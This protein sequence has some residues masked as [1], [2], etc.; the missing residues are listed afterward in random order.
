MAPEVDLVICFRAARSLLK[1]HVLEE[2]KK[3]EEQYTRLLQ[4]LT[5]A[6]LRAV[7]R[8]GDGLGHLVVFVYCPPSLLKTLVKRERQS[9][10]VSGLAVSDPSPTL[11]PADRLRLVYEFVESSPADGGLG[12][13]PDSPS[14]DRVESILTLHDKDFNQ[15]WIH[16]W[17]HSSI[18]SV[19]QERVREH[20]GDSIA[21]YFFYLHSYTH[22]LIF[23][24]ALGLVFFLFG[25]PYSP[26]YSILLVLWSIIY[27]EW[28]RI[29]ERVLALR[30]GTLG[31]ARV[32]RRRAQ[33][34]DGFPWWK[35]ELRMLVGLPVILFFAAILIS[36]LTG[37]FVFEAFLTQLYT[38]PGHKYIAF[39]P[40]ILFVALVPQ[41]LAIYQAIARRI[42]TWEN[43]PHQSSHAASLALKTFALSAL[44]AYMGL[45]LS[46]FVYVPFGE[47]IM[48]TV[49]VWL[50]E[51]HNSAAALASDHNSTALNATAEKTAN[52]TTSIWN[53]DT[54][55]AGQ[56]LNAG[57]LRDQMFAYTVTNQI[58]NTFVEIGLPFVLRKVNSIKDSLLKK[59][60]KGT[61]INGN[62]TAAAA[63]EPASPTLKKRVVF[64]DEQERGGAAERE[65]LEE[66]RKEVALPVYEEFV[67]YSEMVTQFGYVVL[68][69]TIWPLAPVMALVNNFFELRSDAFKLTVHVRRPLPLRTDS[70]GP[71][72]D[73]LGF[74]TWLGALTNSAL[75]YLFC[76]RNTCNGVTSETPIDRVHKHIMSMTAQST[77]PQDASTA[78]RE[79]L[80]KALLIALLASHGYIAVRAVVRH[81]LE[82][83]LWSERA[84]VQQREEKVRMARG[85]FL[86]G[87]AEDGEEK[88]LISEEKETVDGFWEHDEG[89]QE[90][91]RLTK[92][93]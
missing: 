33:Y 8:R 88:E 89:V 56:K 83:L 40:T 29:S 67:D 70:I 91:Q 13:S 86:A 1:R 34:T 4:T 75:V 52:V 85:V 9:D 6:G 2:S 19:R 61:K 72:L 76:P 90:I 87:F 80:L 11:A 51:R 26:T 64:E 62:K 10:F 45:A 14:W 73:A 60:A 32:E 43:H 69:S 30:L 78:A 36:I 35:R 66:V 84:E 92:E 23:P 44:V 7:G 74:L 12:I 93:A 39:S 59:P 24:A 27:V 41:L 58:V 15:H 18:L 21:L 28:W 37:I 25:T 22:S 48:Q 46:A 79:L 3:A 42:T 81:V 16:A 47:G 49:Q 68:W 71:W 54:S 5:S 38:G 53:V 57:R 63:A 50:F 20:F 82:K 17:T 77:S 65:F 55:V 31:S